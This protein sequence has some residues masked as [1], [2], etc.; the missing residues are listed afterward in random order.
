MNPAYSA[1]GNRIALSR[2]FMVLLFTTLTLS[3]NAWGTTLPLL[4]HTLSF[5]GW[6]LIAIA[7]MGRLWCGAHINGRKNTEL[8][9]VG[10]YSIC[11]NPLYFFS[12]LGGL[13]VMLVTKTLLIPLL[14]CV[15]FALYYSTV[16]DSEENTLLDRHGAA[17][18]EY[19]SRVP[20]FWPQLNLFSEPENYRVS[21]VRFRRSLGDAIWYII[22]GGVIEF[23][24]DLHVVGTLPTFVQ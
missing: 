11:R 12:F 9:T 2:F 6:F 5:V 16:I 17:F 13:G 18:Q 3:T 10:P 19:C 1:P 24:E 8:V 4:G 22:A 7:V 23:M 20:R 21:A 14:F 15:L